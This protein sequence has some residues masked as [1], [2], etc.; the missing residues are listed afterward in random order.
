MP[1]PL[2][3][4]TVLA[5][6]RKFRTAEGTRLGV[7]RR[8]EEG[9]SRSR[10]DPPDLKE[11]V[12]ALQLSGSL[13]RGRRLHSLFWN[14]LPPTM[15]PGRGAGSPAAFIF[16]PPIVRDVALLIRVVKN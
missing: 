4:V 1:I 14:A 3:G 8:L 2:P 13:A 5:H 7:A 16:R 12:P 11:M 10:V 6:L 9:G 15:P